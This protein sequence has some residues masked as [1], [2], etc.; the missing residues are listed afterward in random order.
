LQNFQI[1]TWQDSVTC[2]LAHTIFCSENC[3]YWCCTWP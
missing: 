3:K 2:L 1:V